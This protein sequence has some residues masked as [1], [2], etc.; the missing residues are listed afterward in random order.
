MFQHIRILEY[1]FIQRFII[2]VKHLINIFVL[3]HRLYSFLSE[4][5]CYRSI[6]MLFKNIVYC[7]ILELFYETY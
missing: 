5:D 7:R 3:V 4:D 1:E 2:F 6:E